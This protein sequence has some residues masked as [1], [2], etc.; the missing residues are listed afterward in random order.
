MAKSAK[1]DVG[2]I[3]AAIGRED[4]LT[5]ID[6]VRAAMIAD[7][8][9]AMADP[10][11]N[12]W[13]GRR[14]RDIFP[15]EAVSDS[16]VVKTAKAPFPLHL[17][18]PRS[19]RERVARRMIKD[20][21]DEEIASELPPP[22]LGSLGTTTLVFAPGLLTGLLPVLAFQSLWPRIQRRFGIRVIAVDSHPMR[23]SEDNVA[24]LENAIERG[25]SVRTDLD[26]G[27]ITE[28]DS[29]TPPEGDILL[30]G[31]S[32]GS[33]DILTLLARRPDLAPRIRGFIGWAGAVGGS[34]AANDIYAKIKD[35]KNIDVMTDMTGSLGRQLFRLA[36]VVQLQR[37]NRRLDEYD[38]KGAL[39]S[40]TTTYRDE[41]IAEN[42]DQFEELGIPMFFMSGATSIFDVPWFQ[43]Q[44][45]FDLKKHDKFNDMQLTQAQARPPGQNVPHLAMFNANH[46]DLSYDTFPW[47]A[48]MGSTKL[49]N[50][51]A[52][53][54]ALAAIVL[55]MSEI[56]LMD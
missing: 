35:N 15:Q 31:Y 22:Q 41:F 30:M 1:I 51:F 45:T 8:I 24:D 33:P 49:K 12:D 5:V 6:E 34:Y 10:T 18:D 32:K 11:I 28:A 21:S 54:A 43:V 42:Q 2:A 56:G 25:I 4:Y 19:A 50:P 9:A 29:P 16:A 40:L 52:R 38:V 36:P 27:Y 39:N 44:G 48:T 47:Y 46:W 3:H 20:I 55:F 53:E 37:V 7:P 13:L 26:A 17:V 23:S 14:Y